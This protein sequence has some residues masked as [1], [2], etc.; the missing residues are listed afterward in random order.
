M[1]LTYLLPKV[2][3]LML[4]V[5]TPSQATGRETIRLPFHPVSNYGHFSPTHCPHTLKASW[6]CQGVPDIAF[7]NLPL[8]CKARKENLDLGPEGEPEAPKG[9]LAA[10]SSLCV[11]C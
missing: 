3:E 4:G 10:S 1:T 6:T 8:Q 2:L 9:L 5:M 7:S 11:L